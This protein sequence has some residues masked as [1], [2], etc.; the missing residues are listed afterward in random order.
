MEEKK[1]IVYLHVNKINGKI[2]VGIT[3]Q[4]PNI[5]WRNGNGYRNNIYFNK[6]I[7]KY[8]WNSFEHIIVFKNIPKDLACIEERLLIKRYRKQGICYNIANGGEGSQAFPEEAKEKLRKYV[9]PL[10]SQY[11]KEHTLE[12]RQ[13]QSEVMKELWKEQ[14]EHR[15]HM[16]LTRMVKKG[17]E[18]GMY[19]RKP[20][21]KCINR[22]KEIFSKPVLMIDKI[23][24]NVLKEFPSASEAERFLNKKGHHISCCCNGKR[25]TAY[26]YKW[27]YKSTEGR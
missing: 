23:T 13:H 5:R 21:E 18:N 26:G 22:M 2:Y 9:G 1:Y 27:R 24:G 7:N 20:S 15:L 3:R 14:R 4:E 19:G 10:A 12:Q 17:P 6:A 16:L 25:K 11:G 8:G